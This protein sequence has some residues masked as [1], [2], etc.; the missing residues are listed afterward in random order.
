MHS[1]FYTTETAKCDG[2]GLISVPSGL[3]SSIHVIRLENN[4]FQILPSRVFEE[5]G[6]IN[7]QKIFLSNC[8]LGMIAQDAFHQLNHLVELG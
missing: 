1:Y 8:T 3:S 2:Q 6:L 7:L 5:R 4:N